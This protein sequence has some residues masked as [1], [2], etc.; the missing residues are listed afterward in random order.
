M[1]FLVTD[2]MLLLFRAYV[3]MK[4]MAIVLLSNLIVGHDTVKVSCEKDVRRN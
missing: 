2:H 3:V 4:P 1:H